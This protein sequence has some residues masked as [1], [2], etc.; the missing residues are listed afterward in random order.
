MNRK[1]SP[2]SVELSSVQFVLF[3][4]TQSVTCMPYHLHYHCVYV[5]VCLAR[6]L[7]LSLCVCVFSSFILFYLYTI[8]STINLH[9]CTNDERR[10]LR[11]AQEVE[12]IWLR[13][14]SENIFI[15]LHD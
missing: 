8:T 11:S 9:I 1:R 14:L 15:Y 10:R 6:S 2:S 7:S 4:L 5:C 12:F 13:G 3:H